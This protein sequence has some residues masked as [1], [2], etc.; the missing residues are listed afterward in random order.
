[1]H[2]KQGGTAVVAGRRPTNSAAVAK[3]GPP[4]VSGRFGVSSN[5]QRLY[6]LGVSLATARLLSGA[7]SEV[8]AVAGT[9]VNQA[10][11]CWHHRQTD[12]CHL[13]RFTAILEIARDSFRKHPFG[14]AAAATA[15]VQTSRR[16]MKSREH[17][18]RPERSCPHGRYLETSWRTST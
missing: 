4:I 3:S 13:G 2:L 18:T 8:A 17:C 16:K 9:T 10:A 6:F 11:A 15:A 1:M 7:Q 12:S 5:L 14:N